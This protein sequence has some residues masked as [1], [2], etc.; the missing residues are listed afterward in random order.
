MARFVSTDSLPILITNYTF[1]SNAIERIFFIFP[2]FLHDR[3]L[4][5]LDMNHSQNDTSNIDNQLLHMLNKAT[6]DPVDYNCLIQSNPIS[7]CLDLQ[8]IKEISANERITCW[9]SESYLKNVKNNCKLVWDNLNRLFGSVSIESLKMPIKKCSKFSISS[10]IGEASTTNTS[11]NSSSSP[12]SSIDSQSNSSS[13]TSM[14]IFSSYTNTNKSSSLKKLVQHQIHQQRKRKEST[15]KSITNKSPASTATSM[16]TNKPHVHDQTSSPAASNSS[17]RIKLDNS[18]TSNAHIKSED[19]NTASKNDSLNE[20]DEEEIEEDLC[21]KSENNNSNNE[22]EE[23]WDYLSDEASTSYMKSNSSPPNSDTSIMV[24][25][26]GHKSLPYPLR[27]ENGKIIYECKECAKTFGQLSNLKVHLRV[28]TGERPFKCDSCPKGFTQLAHLQ[29]H[30]LVHTGEKPFPCP[31]CGKR[32]SSTSNL[33]TH[34][35]LHNGDRPFECDK[36]DSKFTQ[37]VHLKLHQRL[38]SGSTQSSDK[39]SNGVDSFNLNQ[40][41]ILTNLSVSSLSGSSNSSK[42]SPL[43]LKQHC[44][45]D[46]Y[47]MDNSIDG[48]ISP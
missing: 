24:M 8:A 31:T 18:N 4:G 3:L 43:S 41:E 12:T 1:Q 15:S 47:D 46:R 29:K 14:P 30:I 38:H 23:N 27:K 35:R 32:F 45:D 19:L 36:C 33:K 26:R 48:T 16:Q 37:L 17:K 13:Q 20:E 11:N 7:G 9:F 6:F 22:I 44:I 10:I 34:F 42:T 25:S 5:Y 21:I 39:L 2:V 40:S 28:H